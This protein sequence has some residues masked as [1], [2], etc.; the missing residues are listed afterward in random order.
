MARQ[1][2]YRKHSVRDLGFVEHAGKRIYFNGP[3]DSEESRGE[4]TTFLRSLGFLVY[5]RAKPEG[6]LTVMALVNR[7]DEWAR[8]TLPSGR[9]SRA[10]NLRS[11]MT[12]LIKFAGGMKPAV[13]VTPLVLKE[14]QTWLITDRKV[15]RRYINDCTAAVKQLFKWA[16][17]EE[18]VPVATYQSLMTVPGLQ[19]HRTAPGKLRRDRRLMRSMSRQRCQSSIPPCG[20]WF[21]STG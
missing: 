3:Y 20:R 5:D 9:K 1:P 7:F 11:I 13:N 17:S 12:L 6:A 15:S 19:R 21:N 16:V 18:L 10:A 4:Y 2:K 8:A 14:F